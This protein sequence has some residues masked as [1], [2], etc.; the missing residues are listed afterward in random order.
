[1]IIKIYDYNNHSSKILIPEDKSI[2]QITVVILSGDETGR[3]DFT[4]GSSMSFDASNTRVISYYDG[5]YFVRGE[6][7]QKWI[8]FDVKNC[9]R[10]ISYA[11]QEQFDLEED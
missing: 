4:D 9:K 2:H 11:R 6:N 7:I 10:T 3:I 8:D 1:M 5:G